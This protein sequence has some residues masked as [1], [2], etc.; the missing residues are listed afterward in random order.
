MLLLNESLYKLMCSQSFSLSASPI[1]SSSHH[2]LPSF[3]SLILPDCTALSCH[4]TGPPCVLPARNLGAGRPQRP[5]R[6]PHGSG[7]GADGDMSPDVQTDGDRAEPRDRALQPTGQWWA[8]CCCQGEANSRLWTFNR[9][10]FLFFLNHHFIIN[11]FTFWYLLFYVL[12]NF[13]YDPFE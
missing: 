11:I 7:S 13:I 12:P 9:L 2:Y 5:P 6:R 3:L 10:G 4:P 1:N 8:W